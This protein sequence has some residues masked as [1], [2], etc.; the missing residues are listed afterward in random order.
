MRSYSNDKL[1]P[2]KF[3]LS[4]D[5]DTLSEYNEATFHQFS[6]VVNYISHSARQTAIPKW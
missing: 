6:T 5:P 1:L 3:T 4:S 2:P